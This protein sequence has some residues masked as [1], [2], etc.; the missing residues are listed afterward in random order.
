MGRPGGGGS[1]RSSSGSSHR[2]SS[3]GGSSH[4]FSSSGSG[5]S[6]RPSVSRSGSSY[7][8][9]RSSHV[10]HHSHYHGGGHGYGYGGGRAYRGGGGAGG[11]LSSILLSIVVLV[12]LA[13]FISALSKGGDGGG[14]STIQREKI[15]GGAFDNNCVVQDYGVDWFNESKL[16]SRLKNV[17]WEKT[18]VQ[19]YIVLVG[20]DCYNGYGTAE[21]AERWFDNELGGRTDAL[22][23]FYFEASNPDDIGVMELQ[24]GNAAGSIM[25]SEA[26]DLFWRTHDYYF[27][28]GS[29]DD[30]V[31]YGDMFEAFAKKIMRVSTTGKDLTKW[32][33][34]AVVVLVVGA[35]MLVR[36]AQIRRHKAEEADETVR[37]LEAGKGQQSMGTGDDPLTE[38][39]K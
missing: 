37:I 4:S 6:G 8:G 32:A 34:I 9:S 36:A 16:S 2:G 39:Y 7:S 35:F 33:L 10:S 13:V 26:E 25:D 12:M 30:T 15:S 20:Y 27:E 17:F 3:R 5:R 28:N 18:G 21:W 24:W 31:M 11:C 22:A 29:S 38:K 14:N 19:P 23:Y 1:S